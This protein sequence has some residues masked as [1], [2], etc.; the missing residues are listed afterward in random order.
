MCLEKVLDVTTTTVELELVGMAIVFSMYK[1]C[2]QYG[3]S[4][5]AKTRIQPQHIYPVICLKPHDIFESKVQP[6]KPTL[7]LI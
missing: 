7:L 5:Q 4:M 1:L 6:F 2:R 3:W